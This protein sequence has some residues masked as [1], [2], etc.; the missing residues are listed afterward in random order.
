VKAD[1]WRNQIAVLFI[2]LYVAWEVD[3]EI[4]DGDAIPSAPNTNLASA[5]AAMERLLLQRRTNNF[6]LR[7]GREPSNEEL[8]ELQAISM[9]RSLRRHYS[10]ILEY[11]SAIRI[12]ASRT[13]SPNE[14]RRGFAALAGSFQSWAR[15][16]CHLT[17]Y[18]HL[19]LHMEDQYYH[20]GPCYGWWAFGYERNNGTLGR[21]NHNGHSGGELEATIMRSWWKGLLVHDLVCPSLT[22]IVRKDLTTIMM[23]D[24]EIKAT[25]TYTCR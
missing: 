18:F 12:L 14:V 19:A 10:A 3:G 23:S 15:M 21:F 22:S 4:P 8:R 13:I 2:G 20:L 25:T 24:S 17:P 9:D 1:Q 7:H 16:N 6:R 5:Q 11:S